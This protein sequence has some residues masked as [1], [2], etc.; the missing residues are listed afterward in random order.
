MLLRTSVGLPRPNTALVIRAV[1]PSR[2]RALSYYA[3]VVIGEGMPPSMNSQGPF[4][5]TASEDLRV[6]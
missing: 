1:T 2:G 6:A 3:W 4:V 5:C